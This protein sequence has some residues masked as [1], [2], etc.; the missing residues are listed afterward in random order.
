MKS[1]IINIELLDSDPLIFR[2]VIM[3]A[4]A[5]FYRL[6]Q[7]IQ[8]TSNFLSH[9]QKP[10]HLYEFDMPDL[11]VTSD[12]EHYQEHK[13]YIK[14]KDMYEKRLL[15]MPE[16]FQ[17]FQKSYNKNLEKPV[18]MPD[19]LL[20][21]KY[22]EQY[23]EIKYVY[24]FGDYWCFKISLVKIVE[25][26]YFGYPSLLDGAYSAP[27]E[28]VGGLGGFYDFLKAYRNKKH[29][30]HEDTIK[31]VEQVKFKEYDFD[32]I[33]QQLKSIKYKKTDWSKISHNNYIIIEDKY[34]KQ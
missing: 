8:K 19:R 1:Y 12:S 34:R 31:W 17:E 10:Y 30:E 28:D 25:D 13:H 6:H 26:Y 22:L 27:P 9:S 2:E 24:D 4:N 23:K 7:I 3:P 33:N 16:E 11:L 18:R 14:N 20:I 5:S 32:Y 29:P 15:E 21:D